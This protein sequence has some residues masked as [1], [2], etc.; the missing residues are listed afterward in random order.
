M[1]VFGV[2]ILWFS[3]G[4]CLLGGVPAHL[5]EKIGVKS[6]VTRF[7]VFKRNKC[8]CL[9]MVVEN[10]AIVGKIGVFPRNLRA[11]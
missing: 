10:V 5:L 7:V 9:L 2:Y 6:G 8:T 1:L 11:I 3:K 4:C